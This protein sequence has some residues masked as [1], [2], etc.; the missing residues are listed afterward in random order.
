[1]SVLVKRTGGVFPKFQRDQNNWQ[2]VSMFFTTQSSLWKLFQVL[3]GNF[4]TK[5]LLSNLFLKWILVVIMAACDL[6]GFTIIIVCA[7]LH[8]K[9]YGVAFLMSPHAPHLIFCH[10]SLWLFEAVT[11]APAGGIGVG[12]LKVKIRQGVVYGSNALI[13]HNMNLLG[14]QWE[15]VFCDLLIHLLYFANDA[16]VLFTEYFS[17]CLHYEIT[18]RTWEMCWAVLHW[19]C[20]IRL[21]RHCCIS[22]PWKGYPGGDLPHVFSAL[23]KRARGELRSAIVR[24]EIGELLEISTGNF[25]LCNSRS[26]TGLVGL[27][28]LTIYKSASFLLFLT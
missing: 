24:S 3:F 16:F 12:V 21:W 23:Y 5:S 27:R 17:I 7:S 18:R 9:P 10:A 6:N 14:V 4:F 25:F 15:F 19:A 26:A 13:Y 11:E 1:M 8:P 2:T 20:V 28:A 22:W